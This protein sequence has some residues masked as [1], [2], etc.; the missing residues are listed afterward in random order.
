MRCVKGLN[1]KGFEASLAKVS[2]IFFFTSAGVDL[3]SDI[4][5]FFRIGI[6]YSQNSKIGRYRI[7]Q[8]L[9]LK[10]SNSF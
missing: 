9:H 6:D 8:S 7:Q 2:T 1:E 4:I 5:F 10:S 3:I